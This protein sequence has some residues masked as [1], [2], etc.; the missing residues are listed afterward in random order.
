MSARSKNGLPRRQTERHVECVPQLDGMAGFWSTHTAADAEAMYARLTQLAENARRPPHH[1]PEAGRHAARPGPRAHRRGDAGAGA[2]GAAAGAAGHRRRQRATR[3]ASWPATARSRHAV[4][5]PARRPVH[6]RR[7]G[8]RRPERSRHP[9]TRHR[10]P[11]ERR[12][13]SAGAVAVGAR[14]APDLPVPRLQ[15]PRDR[16]RVRSPRP[17]RRTQHGDRQSRTGLFADV[18]LLRRTSGIWRV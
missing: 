12:F 1:G 14:R 10:R 18:P 7:A 17:V 8:Q 5:R 6:L 4:P 9:R 16:L 13:P 2:A 11:P 3:R 15:P